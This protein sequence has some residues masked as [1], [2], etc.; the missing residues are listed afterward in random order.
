MRYPIAPL[1][2][3]TL[4]TLYLALVL[5]LPMVA[6]PELKP[7]LWAALPLG[8]LP[9][10]AMLSEQVVLDA[11]GIHVGYPAWCGWLLRRGWQLSWAEIAGLVPITTS[12]GGTVHYVK[13]RHG[14]HYLLPQRVGRF[15]DF[16]ERF[17]QGSGL[18]TLRIGRITPPW[19]YW[20]LAVLSL[21]LL[22]GEVGAISRAPWMQVN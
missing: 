3:F 4:L 15:P 2:R 7:W 22:I 11:D 14:S 10:G 13:S 9:V 1:I 5:P 17:Q 20:T 16:L 21:L 18:D 12:Q 6:P 19:T 8:L